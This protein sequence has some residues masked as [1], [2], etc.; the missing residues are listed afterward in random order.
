MV[1]DDVQNHS[2]PE[3]VGA[4]DEAAEIVGRSI[5][6]RRRKE[7]NAVV[8]PAEIAG[9]FGNR[10]EFDDGDPQIGQIGKA[11]LSGAP[12]PFGRECPDVHLVEHLAFDRDSFPFRVRPTKLAGIDDL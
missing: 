1:V 12:G 3:S 10:H 7:A 4:I 11:F 2:Q 8:S 6:A 9:E 5:V